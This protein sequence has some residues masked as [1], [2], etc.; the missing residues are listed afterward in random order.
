MI[1]LEARGIT[2]VF[3]GVVALD[4]V[5]VSFQ[6]GSIHGIVGENGAGK[7]TLIKIL[8]GVYTP[9]QGKVIIEGEEVHGASPLFRKLAYVP[10]ELDLFNHMTVAENLFMPF[11]RTGFEGFVVNRRR[12]FREARVWLDKFKIS[13]EPTD[14]VKDISVSNQQ[15]LQIARAAVS[16][17]F[18]ILVLDEPTTSLTTAETERLFSVMRELKNEG[19]AIIFISHKLDELMEIC[20]EMTVLR[21]G[22]KVAYSTI[23]QVS[24]QWIIEHMTAKEITEDTVFRPE[25]PSQEVLLDVQDLSGLRV[26]RCQFP[27]ACR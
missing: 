23:D 1:L 25:S 20:D 12:M 14:L 13:A 2:K 26:F 3:P 6:A 15:L 17:Y 24:R 16:K 7:S 21:N 22:V 5:D 19:K 27:A 4:N 9:D 11:D 8:T 18:E 10:Q